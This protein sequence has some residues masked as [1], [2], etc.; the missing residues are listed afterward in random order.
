MGIKG[1]TRGMMFIGW[2][3]IERDF[4]RFLI[5]A[6]I[7]PISIYFTDMYNEPE[8]GTRILNNEEIR[9][10]FLELQEEIGKVDPLIIVPM[11]QETCKLFNVKVGELKNWRA[12]RVYGMY[13]PSYAK[14]LPG[15]SQKYVKHLK[16]IKRL[17]VKAFT[18]R[19]GFEDAGRGSRGI[20]DPGESSS[21][22]RRVR[23]QSPRS[24][25]RQ[26]ADT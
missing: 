22:E 3:I 10:G 25:V 4:R 20:A 18:K 12:Y 15:E 17:Y 19:M 2:D 9:Q 1:P 7:E 8:D 16:E 24:T 5:E 23:D 21:G 6:G 26:T 13:R 14:H 11:G